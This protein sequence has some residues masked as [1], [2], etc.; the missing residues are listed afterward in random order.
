MFGMVPNCITYDPTFSYEWA[1]IIQDGLRRMYENQE[2]VFYYLTAMNE[3]YHHPAMPN[4]AAVGILKGMYLFRENS[5][6]KLQLLGSGAILNEVIQASEILEKEFNI[7][8]DIWSVTS[9]NE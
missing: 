6:A 3:N 7:A 2:D 4:N 5:K 1:V 8:S 9:F